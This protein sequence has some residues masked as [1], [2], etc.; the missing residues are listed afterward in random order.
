MNIG[1]KITAYSNKQETI[2]F[3][4]T[5]ILM[6]P[7]DISRSLE[8]KGFIYYTLNVDNIDF[9]SPHFTEEIV[10]ST[11]PFYINISGGPLEAPVLKTG[12][13]ISYKTLVPSGNYYPDSPIHPDIEVLLQALVSDKYLAGYVFVVVIVDLDGSLYYYN[14]FD[15]DLVLTL[16]ASGD[17]E[18][19]G[20]NASKYFID[21]LG[22]LIYTP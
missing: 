12:N 15:Q 11:T 8:I 10:A 2:K 20:A 4:Q 19:S 18:I 22:N 17:L 7:E 6:E 1:F 14:D 16:S 3:L 13:A 5:V 21:P 9:S